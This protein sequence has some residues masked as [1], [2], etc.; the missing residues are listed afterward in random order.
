MAIGQNN[1]Q[2]YKAA[3]N[4]ISS[5]TNIVRLSYFQDIEKCIWNFTT[6][7]IRTDKGI[8]TII[9]T[10]EVEQNGQVGIQ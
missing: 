1:K 8:L 6:S 10:Q 2:I 3:K 7:E 5:S 4:E 9:G